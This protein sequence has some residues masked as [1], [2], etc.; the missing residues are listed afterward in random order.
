MASDV[1]RPISI[2]VHPHASA[3]PA[4]PLGNPTS[5]Y[6]VPHIAAAKQVSRLRYISAECAR[7]ERSLQ[8][9]ICP[10]LYLQERFP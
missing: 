4:I 2:S 7:T 10:L 1:T 3:R 8:G 5:G 6:A 9:P